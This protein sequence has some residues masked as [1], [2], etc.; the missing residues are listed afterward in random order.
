MRCHAAK[1]HLAQAVVGPVP[2]LERFW[3]ELVVLPGLQVIDVLPAFDH[4][5]IADLEADAEVNNTES[6]RRK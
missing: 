5:T 4:E 2:F 6:G 1:E 3:P